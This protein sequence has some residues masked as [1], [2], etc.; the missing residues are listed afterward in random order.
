MMEVQSI[1]AESFKNMYKFTGEKLGKGSFA[2]VREARGTDGSLVA[3]KTFNEQ[4]GRVSFEHEVRIHN[5][6]MKCDAE[7]YR[8]WMVQMLGCYKVS[9]KNVELYVLVF[10]KA[11]CSLDDWLYPEGCKHGQTVPLSWCMHAGEQLAKGL[12]WLHSCSV[13]HC[14]IK[15]ANILFV[16]KFGLKFS[17]L[18]SCHTFDEIQCADDW[19]IQSRWYRAPEVLLRTRKPLDET[20]DVWSLA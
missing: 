3:V 7:G 20:I 19:Y 9:I 1:T 16:D 13:I 5:I 2:C 6:L 14:D 15:P 4:A 17:D 8:K 10:Q 11:V 12:A 18:G